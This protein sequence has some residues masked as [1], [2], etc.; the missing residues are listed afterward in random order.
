MAQIAL[1]RVGTSLGQRLLPGSF[2]VLGR[3]FSGAAL[4]RQLGSLA[5][6]A[7]DEAVFGQPREGPRLTELHVMESREGVGIPNVYGR[8]RVAG[9]LIWA[10][11]FQER[12]KSERQGKG[13]PEVRT[14]SYTV[15]FAVA[16]GEGP[17]AN[18]ERVWANGEELSL[19]SYT[20]RIYAGGETQTPDPVIEAQE[21][22]GNAPGYKGLCYIVFEDFPLDDFGNRIPQLSFEVSKA[23]TVDGAR[24]VSEVV[25]AVNVIPATGE[26]VYGTQ[27]VSVRTFPGRDVPL[28]VNADPAR[29]DFDV[30]LDQLEQGLPNV[31]EVS[32]TVA[33]FGDDLRAEQCKIRPGV[34]TTDR[35]TVP[36]SWSVSGSSRGDAHLVSQTPEGDAYYGG[37]PADIAVREGIENLKSRGLSVT[38]TPFLLMDVPPD[39]TLPNVDGN[40]VQPPFP[41]R[42]R[43]G[44]AVDGTPGVESAV[45]SFMGAAQPSDFT[46]TSNGV[47]YH[48]SPDD[49]GYRRFILHHAYL[50]I[51][52]GGVDGFLIGTEMRGATRLHDGSGGFPFVDGL[53][54][55]ADEIKAILGPACLVSYA[56]DWSEYGAFVPANGTGDVW[57][58][59]DTLWAKPS[60]DY[61]GI[62]WYP[63]AGDW[64]DGDAHLDWQDGVRDPGEATYLISNQSGGDGFDWYYA[65]QV[66]RDAQVRT[67]INDTDH[68]EHWMFRSKDLPNWWS[69]PHHERPGGVR[70]SIP[71]QWQP[72]SKPI[73]LA[74]IGFPAVD[75]SINSPNLF[76]DPKSS[77]SAVPPY[78]S[79]ERDDILQAAAV[80]TVVEYWLAQS[81]VSGAAVWAW[82]A[83]PFPAF[84]KRSD[85][86]SDGDNWLK[87]HWLNGRTS[88]SS[89]SVVFEDLAKRAGTDLNTLALDGVVSG[90]AT[91]GET[92]LSEAIAPL[93]TAYDLPCI[94]KS[95]QLTVL[96]P[97]SGLIT[98]LSANEFVETGAMQLRQAKDTSPGRLTL[99]YPS[100][101]RGY[102]PETADV[103][104][105]EPQPGVHLSMNLPLAMSAPQAERTARRMLLKAREHD[106]LKLSIARDIGLGLTSQTV[107][108]DGYDGIYAV[109]R[110]EVGASVTA[111]LKRVAERVDPSRAMDAPSQS[112][113]AQPPSTPDLLL[114][115]GPLLPSGENAA[116]L[117]LAAYADPWPGQVTILSGPS[118]SQLTE[119]MVLEQ[120]ALTGRLLED[121]QIGPKHRWDRSNTITVEMA[122][123]DLVSVGESGALAWQ[124][125]LLVKNEVGW[126]LLAFATAS[127]VGS[128]TYELTGLLRALRSHHGGPAGFTPAGSPCVLVDGNLGVLALLDDETGLE[129]E[130][131]AQPGGTVAAFT[132]TAEA[133][134]PWTP[135]ILKWDAATG[136]LDWAARGPGV[137][138]DLDRPDPETEFK[139]DLAWTDAAQLAQQQRVVGQS[140]VFPADA[141]DVRLRAIAT[142]GMVGDWV[143]IAQT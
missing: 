113:A 57:F 81:F 90:F 69:Q 87:G 112:G 143:T 24:Q 142:N 59:L 73:R 51:F 8:M 129:Q 14:Y 94:E 140:Y 1:S 123:P 109:D 63:P 139:F 33:W 40:G 89:L 79:G 134:N 131:V 61:V 118:A 119:R 95:G 11:D 102:E 53:C 13:G 50:A 105:D 38:L 103:R 54:A 9:Q 7:I 6:R 114:I 124:N 126:E 136:R 20:H 16:V 4:G 137:P 21:G 77:E 65:S 28:N 111:E 36:Y 46:L 64:R 75:K 132:Y 85:I 44:S 37:T 96:S 100:V 97:A 116:A 56:A 107:M 92:R 78:S 60:I 23:P 91:Y 93:M 82:D 32:L 30:S 43:I 106:G 138:D 26:F 39:T 84:P 18:I 88:L 110:L 117:I 49:W 45:L 68:G 130:W 135:R 41:W 25:R 3:R 58:P 62:D 127:L 2:S 22:F 72:G 76:F 29:S 35:V 66:D 98:N 12:R 99:L 67:P 141:S 101:D 80:S 125:L 122:A 71:T 31:S 128:N 133:Q 34:E 47:A 15:S 55:L 83:R 19:G 108:V 121:L 10:G 42:G 48:G 17:G 5:G 52:A 120:P 86:W 74:E 70:S 115:D 27:P 104:V